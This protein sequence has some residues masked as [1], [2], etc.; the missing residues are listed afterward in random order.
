MIKH[1]FLLNPAAGKGTKQANLH[2]QIERVCTQRGVD[3][4]IYH[5]SAS[6]D[7]TAYVRELC[8]RHPDTQLRFYAC[9]GDGTLS[10]TVN[11]AYGYA[12]AAV[13]VIPVGTGNDFVRNFEGNDAFLDIG[14]Q[15][16]GEVQKLD[17]IGYNGNLCVNMINIG[18]DCEV[19]KLTAKL[20]KI[21]LL[22]ASMSYIAGLVLTLI[23]KPGVKAQ[24][25]LDGGEP[26]QH[27]MLLTS[28]ANGSW[29]GGGFHSSPLALL[30]DGVLDV[31]LI[32]N[33][34][35]VRFLT[36]VKSYKQ[37][38]FVDSKSA[39][40]IID[41]FKAHTVRYTFKGTQSICVDGEVVDVE[42]LEIGVVRDALCL[43]LPRG[44]TYQPAVKPMMAGKC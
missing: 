12:N 32:K 20:K 24:V 3:F 17:L 31:L 28:T 10:E 29:C 43:I 27:S 42:E 40:R 18:F 41:Y 19:V 6:G 8:L 16:D 37:G 22:P 4:E 21:K 35:R 14:A 30:D 25:S 7:A 44:A 5:T 13:G 38:S 2:E 1:V 33:I 9:G 39:R 11:G 23:R 34:T 26:E 15:L 36:L